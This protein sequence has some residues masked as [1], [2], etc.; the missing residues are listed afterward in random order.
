MGISCG[1]LPVL[2]SLP[3]AKKPDADLRLLKNLFPL[4]LSRQTSRKTVQGHTPATGGTTMQTQ[5]AKPGYLGL[6]NAISLGETEAGVYLR[7]WA[8]A[9]QDEDLACVLRLVAARETNHGE[10]FCRRIA[11]LGFDLKPKNDA[12]AAD[13]L[14][15]YADPKISDVDKIRPELDFEDPFVEIDR[16]MEKGVFD[17][18]T[19]NMLNW[20]ITEERDSGRMLREAYSKV[21]AKC[22]AEMKNKKNGHANGHANGNGAAM[23]GPS[24]DAQAIMACMTD[25]FARLEKTLKKMANA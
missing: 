22:E 23:A 10:T 4:T 13:R 19:C 1:R 25:G 11:E 17:P 6:L 24:A 12:G 9:T 21:R 20:Y 18:I 5:T 15:K 14:L 8:N 3:R 2:A 7:A 16:Q